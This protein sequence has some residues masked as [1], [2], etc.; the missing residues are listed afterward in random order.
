MAVRDIQK[1][2][3]YLMVTMTLVAL[4]TLGT[5]IASLYNVGF[6][7]AE[8]R[9][10]ETVKSQARL[11][12][13]VARF[14]KKHSGARARQ[15]TIG[16]IREAQS[17]FHGFGETG[18]F[19]LAEL[20][21]NKILFLLNHRHDHINKLRPIP[22]DADTAE[23]M[24]QALLGRSGTMVGLDYRG[25]R[26]LAAY[27]PVAELNLGVV[28]KMD[29]YEIRAPFIQAASISFVVSLFFILIGLFIFNR[30]ARKTIKQLK[31][32]ELRFKRLADNARV[33]IYRM[34]IPDGVYEYVSP[35]STRI[36][37]IRPEVFYQKPLIIKE[38]ISPDFKSYFEAEWK[39]LL[40]GLMSATYEY[41]IIHRDGS[42]RWLH[43]DN[44]MVCDRHGKVLAIEGIIADITD[45]KR[46][47]KELEH[48]SYV[49]GLTGIAN[50]RAF[51][52]MYAREWYRSMRNS[53]PLS[54]IMVDVD[55]FKQYNDQYGHMK[56]DDA[57]KVVASCLSENIKRASELVA[58]YGGEEFII[59]LPDTDAERALQLAET[60][61][62]TMIDRMIPFE[63]STVSPQLSISLGVSTVIPSQDV[64]S[65]ALLDEADKALYRAK[66]KGRN[67]VENIDLDGEE[68]EQDIHSCE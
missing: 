52:N 35:S 19:T 32:S 56:G 29:L 68:T 7:E 17:Q 58:R 12:E 48:F 24:R 2:N 64:N 49:D 20:K 55:L 11:M 10:V 33:M 54:L 63:S 8:Q 14:D 25:V 40:A 60:C 53:S 44:H 34:S 66:G 67:R 37:G 36:F 15:D 57:L 45:Q 65:S 16:Q 23:P 59:V 39:K 3:I 22:F 31:E 28:A 4:V 27:E 9:L 46:V 38:L 21:N 41:Q 30:S 6:K 43:Q 1:N 47:E 62:I 13:A 26:V 42:L 50:R 61:R 5:A 18:E 51:D